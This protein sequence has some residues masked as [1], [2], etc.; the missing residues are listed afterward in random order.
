MIKRQ[1]ADI[2]ISI[3]AFLQGKTVATLRTLGAGFSASLAIM[4]EGAELAERLV[5]NKPLPQSTDCSPAQS[6]QP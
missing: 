1:Y 2:R 3:G 4:E 6:Q 5:H